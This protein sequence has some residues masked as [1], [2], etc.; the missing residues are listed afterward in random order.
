MNLQRITLNEPAERGEVSMAGD[1][2][3]WLGGHGACKQDAV[4]SSSTHPGSA[5][6]YVPLAS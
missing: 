6:R 2:G 3:M 5:G 4:G 1:L